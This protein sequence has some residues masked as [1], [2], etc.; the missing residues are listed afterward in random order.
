VSVLP[1]RRPLPTILIGGLIAGLL[2]ILAAFTV[3]GFRGARPLRILQAIASGLFGASAF[4]GGVRMAAL[5]LALH[6]VI[7]TVA[8]GAYYL[9]S[10]WMPV[11]VRR[12]IASGAL[13]GV[14]VYAFM[15]FVVIPLSAIGRGPF[16]PSLAMIL[17]GVHIVCVGIP[18]ALVVQRHTRA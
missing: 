8:A 16:V 9:G 10:L 13:Y 7:A 3:Y 15:N 14:A 11:L 17:V 12:P 6:F 4:Q 1:A 18:I 5:G 2:D